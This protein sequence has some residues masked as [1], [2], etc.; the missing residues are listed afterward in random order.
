MTGPVDAADEPV[1]PSRVSAWGVMPTRG[2][3]L[4]VDFGT[5]RIG[6]AVSDREQSLAS[7]VDPVQSKNPQHDRGEYRQVLTRWEPKAIVVGLPLHADG[8]ESA[9]SLRARA[10][11]AWLHGQ[12][13]LP[14]LMHDE[15]YTSLEAN[16]ALYESDAT[17][18][19][20]KRRV[21]GIAAAFMLQSYLDRL[22]N[23]EVTNE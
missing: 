8:G 17:N 14:C 2:R 19:Q 18:R 1:D 23:P 16:A 22:R 20:R 11:A 13:G 12:F 15:R 6:L 9:M 10:H 4:G 7:P 3:L 5:K 21:D